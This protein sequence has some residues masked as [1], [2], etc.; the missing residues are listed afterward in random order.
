VTSG[1]SLSVL[2]SA[3]ESAWTG[4]LARCAQHDFCH[5]PG[6]HRVAEHNGEGEAQLFAYREGDHTIAVPLLLRRVGSRSRDDFWDA[7]SVYGYGG[8]VASPGPVPSSIAA[9]FRQSLAEELRRRRVVSVFSRLHPLVDT[10]DVL[11][12]L[13]VVSDAGRTVS[14]DLAHGDEQSR[15]GYNKSCRRALRKLGDLGLVGV[16]DERMARL[17]EFAEIYQE[18]MRRSEADDWYFY[19]EAY[20]RRLAT[21]LGGALHLFVALDDDR[22]A[23]ASLVTRCDGIMQ[24]YLGGTRAEYLGCSPDRLVVDTERAWGV[25]TGARAL[26][27]GG[28]RGAQEDSLFHYKAGF[29]DRR[30]TFRTWRWIVLPEAYRALCDDA[31]GGGA[32]DEAAGFFPAYRA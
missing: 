2:S 1:G 12:G 16:H 13:G 10:A 32:D 8:P 9:R 22:A 15:A 17:A 28:G 6:F 19:D 27:L 23:A 26:H 4:T 5:L 29:S 18:T 11:D 24:D 31:G 3:D 21:E 14:I 30:H 25:A 7:T 20:F